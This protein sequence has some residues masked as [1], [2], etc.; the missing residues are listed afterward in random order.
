M[1]ER[2]YAKSPDSSQQKLSIVIDAAP[3]KVF[4]YLSTTIGISSWFPELSF[5]NAETILFDM[6]DGNVERLEVYEFNPN[7]RLSFDWFTGTVTFHLN[8]YDGKT[9]LTFNEVVPETFLNISRDFAGWDTHMTNIKD[10]VETG[11]VEERDM[12]AFKEQQHK[13]ETELA[14]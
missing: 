3:E 2:E 4:E 8:A 14:L 6:G 13:I 11:S 10:V 1:I 12:D 5:K 7:E 9:K